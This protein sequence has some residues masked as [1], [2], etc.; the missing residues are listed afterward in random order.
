MT[1][2]VYNT[3]IKRY[4]FLH[5][6]SNQIHSSIRPVVLFHRTHCDTRWPFSSHPDIWHP[7]DFLRAVSMFFMEY[8]QSM[9]RENHIVAQHTTAPSLIIVLI[10][11]RAPLET[12][13][14]AKQQIGA[15]GYPFDIHETFGSSPFFFCCVPHS[16]GRPSE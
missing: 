15:G 2:C 8:R 7:D 4:V 1:S 9:Q 5:L 13:V 3:T 6:S 14:A 11:L 16:A 10:T 12:A